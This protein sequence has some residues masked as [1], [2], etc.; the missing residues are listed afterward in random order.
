TAGSVQDDHVPDL[1]SCRVD[2]TQG[3]LDDRGPNRCTVD[4]N[5]D[6]SAQRFELVGCGRTVRVGSN[7]KGPSTELH[8]MLGEL[9]RGG[10]LA[11]SLKTHQRDDRRV[12]AQVKGAVPRRKE[13]DQLVVDDLDDL[14]T[15]GQR[16]E[17]L[18][19]DGPFANACHEVLD[20]LEV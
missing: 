12:A 11:G 5:V 16:G 6:G 17:H 1:T 9:G 15:R 18:V 2:P 19:A 3:D 10:R 13:F 14:L 8:D 20:D 4:R 7:E